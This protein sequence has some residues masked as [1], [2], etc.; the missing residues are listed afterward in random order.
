MYIFCSEWK[1]Y[2]CHNFPLFTDLPCI[3]LYRSQQLD[4]FLL[5]EFIIRYLNLSS[6]Y[7]MFIDISSAH[8]DY[9]ELLRLRFLYPEQGVYIKFHLSELSESRACMGNF[10]IWRGIFTK[11]DRYQ[12]IVRNLCMNV[13][14]GYYSFVATEVNVF[15]CFIYS[16]FYDTAK[17]C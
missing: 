7:R 4:A 8:S 12:V 15:S 14:E 9:C 16:L 3:Y 17:I 10:F 2:K 11:L 13:C 6:V 5:L 1:R